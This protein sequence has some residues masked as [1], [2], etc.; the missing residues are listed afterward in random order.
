LKE[1]GQALPALIIFFY[2]MFEHIVGV[3]VVLGKFM[4]TI[5]VVSLMVDT[6][7]AKNIVDVS[8]GHEAYRLSLQC[9]A[10]VESRAWAI[11]P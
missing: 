8:A 11:S 6:G 5:G 3:L 10:V 9:T 4:E 7:L 1:T 2:T